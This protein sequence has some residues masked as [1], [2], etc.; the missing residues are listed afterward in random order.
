M[1]DSAPLSYKAKSI[2]HKLRKFALKR[3]A[4]IISRLFPF[5]VFKKGVQGVRRNDP[6]RELKGNWWRWAIEINHWNS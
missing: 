5:A 1:S 4:N 2:L 6:A 3:L